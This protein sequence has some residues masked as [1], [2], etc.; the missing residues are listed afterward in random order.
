MILKAFKNKDIWELDLFLC[1]ICK[2]EF[3][4]YAFSAAEAITKMSEEK[5]KEKHSFWTFLF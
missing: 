1:Y 2:S 5:N 4:G 3:R